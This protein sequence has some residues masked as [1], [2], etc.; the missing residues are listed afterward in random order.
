MTLNLRNPW[1]AVTGNTTLKS[2]KRLDKG[3]N[4]EIHHY[5]N[6]GWWS[7]FLIVTDAPQQVLTTNSKTEHQAKVRVAASLK[8][9][10]NPVIMNG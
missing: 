9:I 5:P 3:I 1:I 10:F 7:A 6:L 2:T 8:R 4:V